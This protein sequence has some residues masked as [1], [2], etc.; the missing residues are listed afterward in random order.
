M[1]DLTQQQFE[2]ACRRRGFVKRE[3]YKGRHCWWAK[4]CGWFAAGYFPTRR[5][6]LAAFIKA[7]EQQEKRT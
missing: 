5:A 2:R 1:R 6:A 7:A 4:S 3:T